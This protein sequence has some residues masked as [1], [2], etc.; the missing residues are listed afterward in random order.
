MLS[1]ILAVFIVAFWLTMTAL[2]IRTELNPGGSALRAVPV[3]H[4][5]KLLFLHEEQS[6]L[7]IRDEG[8]SRGHLRVQPKIDKATRQRLLE[9]IGT[10]HLRLPPDSRQRFSWDGVIALSP[11]HELERVELG[12]VVHDP[13][14]YRLEFLAEPRSNRAL[15]T[16]KVRDRVV[17]QFE[18]TLD[19]AGVTQTLKRAGVDPAA[20]V[21]FGDSRG[22][23]PEVTARQS[24]LLIRGERAETYLVTVQQSGQTLLD[25]H[26]SQIGKILHVKTFLGYVLA[27]DDVLP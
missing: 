3:G 2:L 21:A 8:Q 26:V 27:P 12:V 7:G 25:M 6:D 9:F 19:E 1:R 13:Q 17:E 15:F 10:L 22:I 20:L 16:A 4:V 24:S 18:T 23:R 11:A 5:V 14:S